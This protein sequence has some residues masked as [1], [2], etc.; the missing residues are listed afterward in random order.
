MSNSEVPIPAGLVED[1]LD[2]TLSILCP[3]FVNDKFQRYVAHDGLNLPDTVRDLS[4]DM[5]RQLF[6]VVVPGILN[7]GGRMITLEGSGIASIW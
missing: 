6:N 5:N 7:E 4:P 3:Q 2:H 1:T